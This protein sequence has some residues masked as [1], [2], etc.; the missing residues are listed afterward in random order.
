MTLRYK[1]AILCALLAVTLLSGLP[2]TPARA[3]TPSDLAPQLEP[4]QADDGAEPTGVYG[5]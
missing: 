5:T 2:Q 1:T 3:I 4:P